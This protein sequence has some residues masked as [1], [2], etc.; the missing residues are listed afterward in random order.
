MIRA[1]PKLAG[2]LSCYAN[3]NANIGNSG[4]QGE[5][6]STARIFSEVIVDIQV[7][8]LVGNRVVWRPAPGFSALSVTHTQ[9]TQSKKIV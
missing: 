6:A 2:S 1:A 7:T 5:M 3:N 4:D 8:V 9:K